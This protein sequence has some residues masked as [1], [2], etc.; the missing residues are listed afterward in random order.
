M[1]R[2]GN[3]GKTPTPSEMAR[4]ATRWP[5]LGEPPAEPWTDQH[6]FDLTRSTAWWAQPVADDW[7]D[8]RP[9]LLMIYSCAKWVCWPDPRTSKPLWQPRCLE[10]GVR[11]GTSSMAL[12]HAM[13]ETDGM[14]TSLEMDPEWCEKAMERVRH[15]GLNPW[16]QLH[17][18][19]SNDFAAIFGERLDLLFIDSAHEAAQVRQDVEHY[20]PLVRQHGLVLLHDY[21]SKPWPCEP[22]VQPPFPSEVSI[23]VEELRATGRVELVTLPWSFGLTIGRV[24]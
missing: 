5:V 14:L 15:F 4:V 6:L 3:E 21:W 12:L 22:P 9:H 16:W 11:H 2:F 20:L 13:R 19:N 10:I 18:V 17:C 1:Y 8:S 7:Y 24:L 23:V